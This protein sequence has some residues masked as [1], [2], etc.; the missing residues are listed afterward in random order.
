MRRNIVIGA[1]VVAIAIILVAYFVLILPPPIFPSETL[2]GRGAIHSNWSVKTNET[3]ITGSAI[4]T[5]F[6]YYSDDSIRLYHSIYWG[7]FLYTKDGL[8]WIDKQGNLQEKAL[9]L[10][11]LTARWQYGGKTVP[12]SQQNGSST[13]KFA[14]DSSYYLRVVFSIPLADGDDYKYNSL[15][16]A[17]ESGELYLTITWW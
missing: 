4:W 8:N 14:F 12:T 10:S 1:G 7:T 13:F 2:L 17:W 9:T 3:T 15:E 16:E 5:K 6:A 11:N